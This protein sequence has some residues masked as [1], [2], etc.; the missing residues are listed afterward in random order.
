ME[1][2]SS[3]LCMLKDVGL[4][5]NLFGGNLM[6]W[7]DETAAIFALKTT[8]EKRLVTLRF[9]EIFFKKPVKIG[10]IVD[11][12]CFDVLIKNTSITFKI[13][14]NIDNELVFL[15]DCTF[16]AVDENGNKKTINKKL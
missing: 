10:D 9:G 2:V 4:N 11:F 8:G 7:I 15:T 16:V 3:K 6:S 13:K 12:Y 14:A 1:K 5:N